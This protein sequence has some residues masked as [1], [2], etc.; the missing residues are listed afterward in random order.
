M[1]QMQAALALLSVACLLALACWPVQGVRSAILRNPLG[2]IIVPPLLFAS[3]AMGLRCL[4]VRGADA[5]RGR[6][7]KD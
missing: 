7:P 5:E 1:T 2:G 6:A 4:S 3:L